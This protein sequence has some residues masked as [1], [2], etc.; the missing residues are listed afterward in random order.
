MTTANDRAVSAEHAE[1]A[2][3]AELTELVTEMA[4]HRFALCWF[5]LDEDDAGVLAWGLLLPTGKVI[6]TNNNG[7]T[8]GAFGS[9]ESARKRLGY[10]QDVIL[11][12]LDE[13]RPFEI[14]PS[15]NS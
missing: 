10:G 12:W 13:P 8:R 2:L 5:N 9:A 6:V 7:E 3:H 11:V 15:E 4:P 14:A 1:T